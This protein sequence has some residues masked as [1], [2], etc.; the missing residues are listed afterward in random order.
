[1]A[2]QTAAPAQ[3]PAASTPKT[4]E[5]F[6]LPKEGEDP[7]D[8][9]LEREKFYADQ[10][11]KIHGEPVKTVRDEQ[12]ERSE[13]IEKVGVEKWKAEHDTRSEE[14]KR[15]AVVAGVRGEAKLEAGEVTKK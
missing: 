8:Y 11:A 1:M 10:A 9:K 3:Q 4:I 15:G 13:E 2:T 14:E 5:P 12:M 7:Q 6:R